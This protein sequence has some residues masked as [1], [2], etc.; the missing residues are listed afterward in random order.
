M[1]LETEIREHDVLKS[2]ARTIC[3]VLEV[4]GAQSG[5]SLKCRLVAL[6]GQVRE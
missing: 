2:A 5:S 3:E 4:E 1:V 6:S